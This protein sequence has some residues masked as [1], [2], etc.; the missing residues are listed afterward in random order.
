MKHQKRGK[1][2][3]TLRILTISGV[4]GALF[5]AFT[6]TH[7]QTGPAAAG[8]LRQ[9]A[10]PAALTG[11]A[12]IEADWQLWIEEHARRDSL[13]VERA[14]LQERATRLA[15][16]LEA[17]P[18]DPATGEPRDQ[19][20][21]ARILAEGEELGERVDLIDVALIESREKLRSISTRMLPRLD[22]RGGAAAE[23]P[24]YH[25]F[26][27]ELMAWQGHVPLLPAI[28]VVVRP[29]DTPDELRDKA[30]YLRDLAD[31]LD[32]LAE[33][34]EQRL[35]GF[36]R[37]Q[38]L[39]RGAEEFWEEY[40]FFDEEGSW[41]EQGR[42]P[43]LIKTPTGDNFGG[44]GMAR[45]SSPVFVT[46]DGSWEL[47]ALLSE[48]P[49]SEEE[50]QKLLRVLSSAREELAFQRDSVWAQAGRLEEEAVQR[51]TP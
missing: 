10:L 20:V 27:Q 38:R 46:P 47:D 34:L 42:A 13:L 37:Q 15:E 41:D 49:S 31:G 2:W 50:M 28:N 36:E 43:L 16:A 5:F 22:E 19:D 6:G 30:A 32:H 23:E 14:R 45:G 12:E 1:L 33:L 40:D 17:L 7:A 48:E 39:M 3:A 35:A 51:E 21:H 4:L 11:D 9:P 25:A 24:G 44:P 18:V 8:D 26:R 29:E